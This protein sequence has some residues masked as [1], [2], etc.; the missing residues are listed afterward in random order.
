MGTQLGKPP[1]RRIDSMAL[2][3]SSQRRQIVLGTLLCFALPST[4]FADVIFTGDGASAYAWALGQASPPYANPAYVSQTATVQY[5]IYTGAGVG[6]DQNPLTPAT[7][8]VSETAYGA[9]TPGAAN[10]LAIS[11][12][13]SSPGFLNPIGAPQPGV[14]LIASASWSNVQATVQGPPG[15]A[16]PSSIRLEFNVTYTP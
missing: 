16:P 8:N 9:V 11:S 10:R 6:H 5:T 2:G 7:V 1:C 4:C 12:S 14:D 15:T 13:Y 3:L